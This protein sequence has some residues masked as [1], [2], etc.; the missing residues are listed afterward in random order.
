MAKIY[1]CEN[2]KCGKIFTTRFSLRRH[3]LTHMN[4]KQHKCPYCEKRFA[5]AQYLKEHIY[6]HTGER[7][8]VCKFPS[9]GKSF[10]QAGKLSI[11]K[12]IHTFKT[13]NNSSEGIQ[14]G[15]GK[16]FAI[17]RRDLEESCRS[18]EFGYDSFMR[19]KEDIER[20]IHRF[21]LP[22][23]FFTRQ[24]PMPFGSPSSRARVAPINQIPQV[25]PRMMG[26]TMNPA[27]V[28]QMRAQQQ[29]IKLKNEFIMMQSFMKTLDMIKDAS[30][31]QYNGENEYVRSKQF[32]LEPEVQI[33]TEYMGN[34]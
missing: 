31:K 14:H 26:T 8:F 4:I 24:L 13:V 34:S 2:A 3:T 7:P 16:I 22:D 10:R 12:K 28:Q 5:L 11:H 30:S 21:S 27:M 20:Q 15:N 19:A 33:K 9:C 17:I 25:C 1:K 29:Q 23:F 32:M 18:I 6:I